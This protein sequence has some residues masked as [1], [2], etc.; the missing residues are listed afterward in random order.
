MIRSKVIKALG[1]VRASLAYKGMPKKELSKLG[2][3]IA[4]IA[5]K[6]NPKSLKGEKPRFASDHAICMRTL[7]SVLR[8]RGKL[9]DSIE[10]ASPL[11]AADVFDQVC[12]L[13]R[14]IVKLR[15]VGSRI[16]KSAYRSN[17]NLNIDP[18]YFKG[19]FMIALYRDDDILDVFNNVG[20]M[21]ASTGIPR[22]TVYKALSYAFY[23]RRNGLTVNG[24]RC[25]IYFINAFD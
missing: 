23:G 2:A 5:E 25:R 9:I 24:K 11:E 7:D 6:L 4:E 13:S 1:L 20:E 16:S 22:E 18:G 12:A 3:L 14:A 19:R 10:S 15:Y 17:E 8:A 21:S